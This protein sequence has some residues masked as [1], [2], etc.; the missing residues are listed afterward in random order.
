MTLVWP[1]SGIAEGDFRR[2]GMKRLHVSL[3]TRDKREAKHRHDAVAKIVRQKRDEMVEQVRSGVL[4]VERLTDMVENHELLVPITTA[5]VV[6]ESWSTVGENATRYL[7]W[8]KAHRNK[9]DGTH[10]VAKYQLSLFLAFEY[11]GIKTADRPFGEIP[12]ALVQAYQQAFVDA[13]RSTNVITNCMK[14]VGALWRWAVREEGKDAMEQKRVARGLY[15]P[16][17]RDQ[18]INKYQPRERFLSR[19]EIAMLLAATPDPMLFPVYCG[20]GAG[21]R[22]GEVLHLRPHVDVDAVLGAINIRE[23]NGWKPKTKRS[24]RVVPMTDELRT[25]AATHTSRWAG[26]GCMVPS[27]KDPRVIIT[28]TGF[29]KHFQPIVERAGMTYGQGKPEGVTFHTLRHTFASHAVMEGVDLYTLAQILGDSLE[30]VE[31]TYAHLSPDFKRSAL[32]KVSRAITLPDQMTQGVT[33]K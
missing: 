14:R 28:D 6:L 3:R 12:R 4:P 11:E 26:K 20:L 21:L 29:R 16:V 17:D 13:E 15:S 5:V 24:T 10:E 33:Q 7:D 18:M 1:A 32:A 2:K 27:P 19:P 8:V 9:S 23:H 22:L 30:E 25:I 31:R